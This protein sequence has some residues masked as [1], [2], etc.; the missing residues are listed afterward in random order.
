MGC[1]GREGE[2]QRTRTKEL[3]KYCAFSVR[4]AHYP[5]PDSRIQN[6]GHSQPGQIVRH[7][8]SLLGADLAR[9]RVKVT[10]A[11]RCDPTPVRGETGRELRPGGTWGKGAGVGVKRRS[12]R[13]ARC[14]PGGQPLPAAPTLPSTHVTSCWWPHPR[15]AAPPGVQPGPALPPG[16]SRPDSQR[17]PPTGRRRTPC[18][19]PPCPPGCARRSSA[20][21]AA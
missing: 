6:K 18:G 17:G 13:G 19:G 9:D 5:R 7:A 11:L 15:P 1:R 21:R 14:R 4:H 12:C 3:Y 16:C 10:L 20:P 2:I 8:M